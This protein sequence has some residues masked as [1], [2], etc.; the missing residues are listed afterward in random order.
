M[1]PFAL[2]FLAFFKG[3]RFSMLHFK[4]WF[5]VP[6][7]L[8]LLITIGLSFQLGNFLVPILNEWFGVTKQHADLT[9]IEVIKSGLKWGLVLFLQLLFWYVSSRFMKYLVLLLLS[10]MFAYLSQKTDEILTSKKYPF[11]L[12]QFL[13]DI[14]RGIIITLRN[15]FLESI[16]IFLGI[17]LSVFF[18][19]FSPIVLMLLFLLNSYFMAFNFFDYIAE[20]KGLGVNKSIRYMHSNFSTLLGFGVAYNLVSFVPFLD[21]VLAPISAASGAVIADFEKSGL[22]N[23]KNNV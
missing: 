2:G 19:L 17:I 6:V 3:I 1:H 18:P 5:L 9:L 15:A 23:S 13:S 4:K 7:F 11:N 20:R 8:W 10:P 14:K 22:I 12:L 21:W 16:I